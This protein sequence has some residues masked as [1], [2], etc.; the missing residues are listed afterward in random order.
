MY[1]FHTELVLLST[2][3][4]TETVVLRDASNR[5]ACFT[6]AEAGI[7]QPQASETPA[8]T[9]YEISRRDRVSV[10]SPYQYSYHKHH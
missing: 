2:L 4:Q 10:M 5:L 9:Q 8:I 1:L 7:M 3:V 6:E